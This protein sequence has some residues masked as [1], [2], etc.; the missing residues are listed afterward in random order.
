MEEQR[1]FVRNLNKTSHNN[2]LECLFL[3]IAN[4]CFIAR[5]RVEEI[6][7]VMR[8]YELE[9]HP[10]AQAEKHRSSRSVGWYGQGCA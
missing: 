5:G 10:P 8:L 4:N 9:Y 3:H 6:R 2:E 7:E 1:E